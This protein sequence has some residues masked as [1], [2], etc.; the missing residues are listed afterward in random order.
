MTYQILTAN[1]RPIRVTRRPRRG[2][3]ESIKQIQIHATRGASPMR[4][5]IQRTVS[6]FANNRAWPDGNNHGS[7]GGSADLLVGPDD[8]GEIQIIQFGN[9]LSTFSS[10]SAGFGGRG[11]SYEYGAA[12]VGVAIELSQPPRLAGGRYQGGDSDV[13]FTDETMDALVWLCEHINSTLEAAGHQPI[14]AQRIPRWDQ[15]LGEPIPLGYIGHEDLANGLRGGKTDPGMMFD[16]PWFMAKMSAGPAGQVVMSPRPDRL[17]VAM[18]AWT[19]GSA[20]LPMDGNVRR[21]EVRMPA[22]S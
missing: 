21:Y 11:P 22:G 8:A 17:E 13:P 20:P 7:W 16:W 14:L 10:W 3:G 2:G 6:Y 5:Q 18:R 19:A 9:W 15:Q 12:E 1:P 4:T